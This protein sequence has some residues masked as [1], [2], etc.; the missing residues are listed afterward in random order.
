MPWE[1]CRN[2][3]EAYKLKREGDYNVAKELEAH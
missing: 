3:T 1:L 2:S